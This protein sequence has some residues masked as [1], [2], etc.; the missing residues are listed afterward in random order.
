MRKLGLKPTKNS[1]ATWI[2]KG[3]GQNEYLICELK[4]TEKGSI[5]VKESD[6][7][8]LEGQA[9]VCNKIPLFAIQYINNNNIYIMVKPD[10]LVEIAKYLNTGECAKP[11]CF[12]LEEY[13]ELKRE[14]KPKIKSGQSK[15]EEF[16]KTKEEEYKKWK[17]Q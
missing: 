15:R 12:E 9:A 8:K 3:D 17:R 5:S 2:E 7:N 6:L 10:D 11:K 16:W 4:S 13:K 1:G 14:S